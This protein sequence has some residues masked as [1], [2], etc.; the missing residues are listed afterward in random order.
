MVDDIDK[1][2]TNRTCKVK[3]FLE[4]SRFPEAWMFPG[5]VDSK[6]FIPVLSKRLI[7]IHI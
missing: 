3:R 7:D 5:S 4:S 2:V 1:G 6:A